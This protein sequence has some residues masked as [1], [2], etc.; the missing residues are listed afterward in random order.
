MFSKI[1]EHPNGFKIKL[2]QIFAMYNPTRHNVEILLS[3]ILNPPEKQPF[4]TKLEWLIDQ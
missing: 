2:Q 3:A 1:H 4:Q